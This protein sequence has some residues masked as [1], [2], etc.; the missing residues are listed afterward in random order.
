LSTARGRSKNHSPSL[1][2]KN[3]SEGY[4]PGNVWVISWRANDLKRDGTLAEFRAMVENWPK[5][6][7]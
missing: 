2:R 3:S 7:D 6:G 4:V 5:T 1:D